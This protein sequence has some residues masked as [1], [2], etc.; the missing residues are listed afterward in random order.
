[1]QGTLGIVVVFP[2]PLQSGFANFLHGDNSIS[3]FPLCRTCN[4]CRILGFSIRDRQDLPITVETATQTGRF[5]LTPPSHKG[6]LVIE[7]EKYGSFPP[8][9]HIICRCLSSFGLYRYPAIKPPRRVCEHW[10]FFTTA[11][12]AD[13]RFRVFLLLDKK[14][15]VFY[16]TRCISVNT[17]LPS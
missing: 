12:E 10:A 15:G 4:R 14:W 1:M 7:R 3:F 11:T 17:I 5:V 6:T 9:L 2:T 16:W 13:V 8:F